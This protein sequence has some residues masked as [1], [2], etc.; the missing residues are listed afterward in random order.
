MKKSILFAFGIL[1][2]FSGVFGEDIRVDKNESMKETSD[3]VPVD[4]GKTYEFSA[5]V[6]GKSGL[7]EM[8]LFQYDRQK[9]RLGAY[10]VN[11]NPGTET[12]L[13]APAEQGAM[14]FMAADAS[15]WE[16]P[17]KGNIVVFDARVDLS[18]LPNFQTEYYVKKVTRQENGFQIDLD[19]KLMRNYPAG[20]MVRLHMDGGHLGWGVNLPTDSEF[21]RMIEPAEKFGAKP[22]RWWQGT[23]FVRLVLRTDSAEPVTIL[24]WNL[25]EIPPAELEKRKQAEQAAI[26]KEKQKITPYGYSR[27]LATGN[28]VEEFTN[29]F[30]RYLGNRYYW[31]GISQS[32]LNLPASGIGQFE[33]DFKSATPGVLELVL[34]QKVAGKTVSIALSPQSVI[35]D[36]QYRRFIFTPRESAQWNS[37]SNLEGWELRFREY[38]EIDKVIGFRNPEF[39]REKNLIPSAEKLSPGQP[40]E[41]SGLRP[42]GKYQLEWRDGI[43][44]GVTLDFF[45]HLLKPI[46]GSRV[47]LEPGQKRCEFTA[48]EPLI[49]TRITVD[50][51][52]GGWPCLVTQSYRRRYTPELFWRGQWIWSRNTPGPDYSN[53]WFCKDIDLPEAPEYAAIALMADDVSDTFVNGVA[54]GSTWPYSKAFRFDITKLLKPGR[55]RIAV[56]VYNLD[57]AAGLC[58]DVYLKTPR[59]DLWISTDSS[60]FC[61]ET[62][63]DKALPEKLEARAVELGPP[64]TTAPWMAWIQF[65]YAGPRGTFTLLK[66]EN[67]EFTAR[68]ENP[69]VSTF[70]TLK[71]ERCSASGQK[72]I[73][74]LPATLTRNMDGTVTVKYPK[75]HPTQDPCK[76]YL[77][78]DF[79]V[80]TGNRPLAEL[81]GIPPASPGLQK[82]EFVDVGKHTKLKFN[83]K[84]L[85]PTFYFTTE[86]ARMATARAVGFNSFLVIAKF[87]EFWLDEGRYDFTKLDREIETLLTAAPGAIFMLD[88]RFYMPDWWL[89]KNPDDVSAYFE[90]TRRNT[91]DDL[92]ALGSKNWLAASEA[93]LKALLDHVKASPYADRI[94]GANIGDSRGNEWFWGGATAGQDFYGK[95]AQPGY[96]PSDL[97]AFRA[98]LRRKYG[99]DAALAKA[100]RMPGT[101]IDKAEMPDHKLRRTGAVGSLLSPETDM[102]I[103]DWCIFRNQSLA[104]A[105]IHFAQRIKAHTDRKWLVGAYYGYMTELS[106]NPGRS[107]LI[108]GHNGFLDCAKSP[109]VDFFR[110]PSRYTYRKTGMPNGVMQ[111][112]STFS[113]RGKVVFIENDERN[114]YGPDE[115]SA[116]NVYAGCGS[117]ALESIGHINREFGMFTTL[118]IA[119][120]WMDH[121]RGS[122]YEPAL[123]AAIGEQLKV[124]ESL[125]PVQD[126]TPAEVSV[127]GDVKSI[128]GSVDGL[129][130]IFPPAVSGVFKRLNYLGVPFRSL[131]IG[132]LLE[133][134]LVP[135]SKFYIMLPAL[136]LSKEE[137]EK[138]LK[139]FDR[140]KA[141][142]LW[143]YSA[144]SSYPDRGPKGEYCGDFLGLK[145]TMDTGKV[146]ERLTTPQGEYASLF[147]G[148]PH[149]YPE[150]G[151]DEVLGR[152]PAGRPVLVMKKSGGAKQIFSTLPDLPKKVIGDLLSSAGVF[153]YTNS[154]SDPLWI[155]N[156]LIF[157]HAATG[158]EKQ[159]HLPEGLRMQAVIGPLKGDFRSGQKWNAVAGLTYGFL[160]FKP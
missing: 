96:S 99:S 157:L 1:L 28:G 65:A 81:A 84:L 59:R 62:G 70:R 138:L 126:F 41:I 94:W 58:A 10:H 23:A 108:T 71:F 64:A 38:N 129:D 24:K 156:D 140:E 154:L 12:V 132:D 145:C 127:V 44:P 136:V 119:H 134:D 6:Q 87:D 9:R 60:W 61:K 73:F 124:Y 111:T 2:S 146:E 97:A 128:Y 50:S 153:R 32:A 15:K 68:M 112:F 53:V 91:Y 123:M 20:T 63:E 45:D 17:Q 42:L 79:W 75:L 90:K 43:C 14:S 122:L 39:K 143:L 101:T 8:Y 11:A 57:Q 113:L 133:K 80:I 48:P 82:A 74:T 4:P 46:P 36:G 72:S 107:Q 104:E 137:R 35:P 30:F 139:R 149:F 159:I 29:C 31:S 26:L 7:L 135:P 5:A 141:M 49:Q 158:G 92:Q 16:V 120:Y 117:T 33:C 115:G 103:M 37:E 150:S 19:R 106:D 66:T 100:W 25:R 18:D 95:P 105:I 86:W 114:A 148:A 55:N 160:V 102:R 121:P 142:V 116:M 52:N 76:V 89:K 34:R 131:V 78:D 110:A 130:G 155:G 21:R 109:D 3:Y 152:N 54:V 69:V 93:P 85:D 47:R 22:N 118:G 27:I 51:G 83:G 13:T 88:I 125:P 67:G 151:Y 77:D 56:R 98:M 144:G 40:V 147:S